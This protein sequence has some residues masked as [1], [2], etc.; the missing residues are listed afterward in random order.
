MTTSPNL[1]AVARAATQKP[2]QC[3]L[4]VFDADGDV[5]ACVYDFEM[6]ILF[7]AATGRNISSPTGFEDAK[8]SAAYKLAEFIVAAQ[9]SVV[10][11]L[12]AELEELKAENERLSRAFTTITA[13]P[14]GCLV[15]GKPASCAIGTNVPGRS[16]Q[17]M[18]WFCHE[19]FH[20][21]REKSPAPPAPEAET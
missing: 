19:H 15:C 1:T 10:L 18:R 16:V 14:T 7:T 13:A 4:D 17:L 9:P 6:E 8:D 2:L 5:E 11:S 21:E 20:L 3:D 12:L